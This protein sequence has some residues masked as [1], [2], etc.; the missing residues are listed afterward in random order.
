MCVYINN[1]TKS[2][3]YI[4]PNR[5]SLK[6]KFKNKLKLSR[7]IKKLKFNKKQTIS[8]N[9]FFEEV[10]NIFIILYLNIFNFFFKI[11]LRS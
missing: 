2:Q 6:M 3:L 8:I 7:K 9:F 10:L 5:V 11:Y 4:E 1:T